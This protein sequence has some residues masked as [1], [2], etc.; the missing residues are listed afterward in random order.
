M[1]LDVFSDDFDADLVRLTDLGA[2]VVTPVHVEP[3]GMRLTVLADPE[4][5]EFCLLD[6]GDR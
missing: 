4:G 3:D 1:H 2:A 5:N 6:P